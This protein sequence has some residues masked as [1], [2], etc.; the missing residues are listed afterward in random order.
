MVEVAGSFE[1]LVPT[2]P[3]VEVAC[4]CGML[5]PIYPYV[6]VAGSFELLVP[7]Y[8]SVE[9]AGFFQMLVP[10]NQTAQHNMNQ[11][12]RFVRININIPN[13]NSLTSDDRFFHVCV[14]MLSVTSWLSLFSVCHISGADF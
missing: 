12:H 1:V 2:Y 7:I 4:P 5:V 13:V 11:V 8:P 14:I 3:S 9:V 10:I 6:E